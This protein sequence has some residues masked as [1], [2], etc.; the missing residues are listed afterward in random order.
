MDRGCPISRRSVLR[1]LS[2]APLLISGFTDVQGARIPLIGI[3]A[4]NVPRAHLELGERSPFDGSAGFVAALRKRGWEDGKTVRIVWRSAEGT[5]EHMPLA[6]ELAG[7]PVDVIVGANLG[8]NAA[9]RATRTIPLVGFALF[10][11]VEKG[12]AR[13]LARPGGN[14]TGMTSD[15]HGG[16][17]IQ[18]ALALL[19]ELSPGIRTVAI[20][21]RARGGTADRWPPDSLSSVVDPVARNLGLHVI[22][23]T[24]WDPATLP[25]LVRSTARQGAQ[26]LLLSVEYLIVYYR[27]HR[28]ALAEEAAR[29]RLPVM[30][31]ALGAAANGALMSYGPNLDELWR[32]A[33]YFVDRILRGDRPGEI[34][35]E[36][37]PVNAEFHLNRKAARA[38][39]LEIPRTLLL[40]A[41]RVFD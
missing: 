9:M 15:A 3:I 36:S 14:L 29:L 4:D 17:D 31:L 26:A 27:E 41:D 28:E 34:P 21:A 32:R 19:K 2:T 37:P 6:S 1:A 22:Y 12:Y 23:P 30:H 20:V 39:G 25:E 11:P 10:N 13:S 40:Q 7:I 33:A 24:Y 8:I 38:I 35:I 18:K 16:D 5:Y